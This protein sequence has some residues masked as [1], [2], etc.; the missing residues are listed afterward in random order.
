MQSLTDTLISSVVCAQNL[1]AINRVFTLQKKALS[2][3]RFQPRDCHPSPLFKKHNL[4]KFEDKIQLENVPPIN[5]YFNKILPSIFDNWFKLSS[6]IHN[7][8]TAP[9][10]TCVWVSG[11]EFDKFDK[12]MTNMTNLF[13]LRL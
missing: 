10:S 13:L 12:Y 1:N 5:K 3:I 7:Y 2:I 6:D 11:R 4:L 9:S 8:N